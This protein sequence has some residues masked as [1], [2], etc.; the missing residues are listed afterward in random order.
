MDTLDKGMTHI[1]GRLEQSGATRTIPSF[2]IYKLFI[3]GIIRLLFLDHNS[4][5]V[6]KITE[7]KV[8]DKG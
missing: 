4:P 7:S 8:A 2:K 3:S 5:Q 1:P 6:T